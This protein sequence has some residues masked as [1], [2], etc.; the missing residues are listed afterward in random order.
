MFITM[1]RAKKVA[2]GKQVV[3]NIEWA[4]ENPPD[5]CK[6]FMIK[7]IIEFYESKTM[8]SLDTKYV[9][10]QEECIDKFK[11]DMRQKMLDALSILE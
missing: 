3:P 9:R 7:C 10:Y 5:S 6:D 2:K 8:V 1:P 11:A 4:R